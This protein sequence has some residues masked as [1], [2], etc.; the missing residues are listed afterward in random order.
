MGGDFMRISR[1]VVRLIVLVFLSIGVA[2]PATALTRTWVGGNGD[3]AD[4]N[5]N[6]A[7]WSG[8]DE[9]DSDDVAAFNTADAVSVTTDNLVQG[10]TMSAGIDLTVAGAHTLT[11][12][13]LVQLSGSS[14][15]LIISGV[16]STVAADSVT[17]NSGGRIQLDGGELSMEEE[18]GNGLFTINSGGQLSGFGTLTLADTPF[19]TATL[20]NNNGTITASRDPLI[21]IGTPPSGTLT[22][23]AADADTRIDLD[24]SGEAGVVNINRNQSLDVSAQ[25]SDAFNGTLNMAHNTKLTMASAWVMAGG[26]INIHNGFVAGSPPLVPAIPASK[27]TIAGNFFQQTGGTITVEDGDGTLQFDAVTTLNG[28]LV[29]N[30]LLIFNANGNVASTANI[31]MP[32]NT[33]SITVNAGVTANIS[34]S[35]FNADGNGTATNVL[36]I[37]SGGNLTLSN[38]G[39]AADQS[40]SGLIQLNGGTLNVSTT[41]DTWSI[42]GDVEVA[43]GTGSSAITGEAL[44]MNSVGTTVGAGSTLTISAPLT[45]GAFATF[46]GD[47]TLTFNSTSNITSNTA[48]NTAKFDWDG[49]GT[50][51]LHTIQSGVTF[52]VN[53]PVLDDDGDMDDPVSLGGNGATLA[54]NGPASWEMRG[55]FT[56][57]T[58]GLGIAHI[59]GTSRMIL[60]GAGA[61]LVVN[62]QTIADAPLT[63]GAGSTTNIANQFLRL[64][65]GNALTTFNEINGGT[66]NGPGTLGMPAGLVLRGFG[67]INTPVDFDATGSLFADNGTLTVGGSI[68]DVGTIGTADADGVLNVVNAWNSSVA[69]DVVLL[70]GELKG[71]TLTIGNTTGVTGHGLISA[72]V[73]NS[74]RI[75]A[76]D[77]TLLVETAGNDNDWDGPASTGLLAAVGG[78]TL[79]VRDNATFGFFGIV[80]ASGN[81]RVFANFSGGGGLDFNPGSTLNLTGSKYQSAGNTDIGGLVNISAGGESTIE[82]A[83]NHFLTFESTSNTTLNDNLKR[84]C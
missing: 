9:P 3:W 34:Q 7:N 81:S 30:G 26:T 20:L 38:L 23:F 13:G 48:I 12:D 78:A 77:G 40:L 43:A 80:G 36:T 31:T 25:L 61:V 47:G 37:N 62:G 49:I 68:A 53:S 70:G 46:T 39:A 6:N 33:S 60:N 1:F 18:T 22:L 76:S 66:I 82:V 21:I 74:Q 63:F 73:I 24:G 64:N 2:T 83:V 35:N 59:G 41:D 44:T 27:S 84:P 42:D 71:G 14:T 45:V 56:T 69:E 8:F 15:N 16:G 72:R 52:T 67:T 51:T 10:L 28:N 5:I 17:I 79:E 75:I 19:L 58:T 57:N 65:G 50:G 29:N 55:A 32:T 11:V 4:G 54:M